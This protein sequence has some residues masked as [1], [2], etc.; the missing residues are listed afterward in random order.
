M[1]LASLLLHHRS[2]GLRR[3]QGDQPTSLRVR[4]NLHQQAMSTPD[5]TRELI[6]SGTAQ[7]WFKSLFLDTISPLS[8][9]SLTDLEKDVTYVGVLRRRLADADKALWALVLMKVVNRCD[10]PPGL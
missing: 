5:N 7:T 3:I 8:S 10:F 9:N 4:F 6:S 2:Y 1:T